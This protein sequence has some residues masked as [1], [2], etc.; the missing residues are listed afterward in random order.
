[1]RNTT[2][3][4][5]AKFS[6]FGVGL[7]LLACMT[8]IAG[9]TSCVPEGGCG[10][11]STYFYLRPIPTERSVEGIEVVE[12]DWIVEDISPPA[13]GQVEQ[14]AFPQ[15]ELAF[16]TPLLCADSAHN[17]FWL[18]PQSGNAEFIGQTRDLLQPST[19]IYDLTH[20][21]WRLFSDRTERAYVLQE[22]A[23]QSALEVVCVPGAQGAE[24]SR[25]ITGLPLPAPGQQA[26]MTITQRGQ[27]L[28]AL[29]DCGN[30]SD[31]QSDQSLAGHLLRY[32]LNGDPYWQNPDQD[33]PIYGQGLHNPQSF[34]RAVNF[35]GIVDRRE[36]AALFNVGININYGW[37]E[38]SGSQVEKVSVFDAPQP[39]AF[40]SNYVRGAFLPEG[41][42]GTLLW[43]SS[44]RENALY[45]FNEATNELVRNDLQHVQ[46]L[47]HDISATRTL[48]RL[49]DLNLTEMI[50]T[51]FEIAFIA[52][53]RLF[54]ARHWGSRV[55]DYNQ[56]RGE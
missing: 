4:R 8:L 23:A 30:P 31:A 29:P 19:R 22:N 46:Y 10:V 39:G 18:D 55:E 32:D 43:E 24:S 13:W 38:L 20:G 21:D 15:D 41:Y 11:V 5:D 54:R 17:I 40:Y 33:S 14:I 27:L 35:T 1:M 56:R 7:M 53:G 36:G 52:D 16:N 12:D 51:P 25:V 2:K 49:N 44:A 9:V 50:V 26:A 28:I 45:S 34:F 6:R 42:V 37:P 48:V 47:R 3:P